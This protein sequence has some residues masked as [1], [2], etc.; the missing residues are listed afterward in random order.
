MREPPQV[1]LIA[2][3][4]EPSRG[5]YVAWWIG[6]G[7][8]YGPSCVHFFRSA[9]LRSVYRPFF[10]PTSSTTCFAICVPSPDLSARQGGD[11]VHDVPVS[12]GSVLATQE[13]RV[14][15]VHEQ[16]EM[17]AQ[18]AM[19]VAHPL[20][21]RRMRLHQGLEGLA[22]R[23]CVQRHIARSAGEAAVRAVK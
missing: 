4:I 14:L 17:R 13:A 3:Y 20:G 12:E 18:P 21:Q 7:A 2:A 16:A 6:A 5:S 19:L 22:K 11:H 1:M 10:V 15:L 23:R 8:L 9:S